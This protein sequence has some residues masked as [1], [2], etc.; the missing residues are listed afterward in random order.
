M[1]DY[2]IELL[3]SDILLGTSKVKGE[4]EKGDTKRQEI[5]MRYRYAVFQ[6]LVVHQNCHTPVDHIILGVHID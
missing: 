3:G 1:Q 5:V 6:N 4:K 2:P